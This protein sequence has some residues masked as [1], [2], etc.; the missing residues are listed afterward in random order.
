MLSR[1]LLSS[2]FLFFTFHLS[3]QTDAGKSIDTKLIKLSD[4]IYSYHGKG[5]NIGLSVGDDGIFMVDSQHEESMEGF[6][7][8][9]KKFNKSV[10]FL[11]NTHF[12]QDHTGGN[13]TMAKT[14]TIIVSQ[15]N[16][17]ERLQSKREKEGTKQP[18]EILPTITFSEELTFYF[19]NE[20]IQLIHIANAHTDGDA[21]VYFT[22]SNI[23]HTGDLL[24]NGKYPYIDLENGGNVR[25]RI[26]GLEKMINL[27]DKNTKIIPGHGPTASY[28]DLE[29]SLNLLSLT[30]RKIMQLATLGKTEDEVAKMKD[31]V[32]PYDAKGYGKGFV[33]TEDFLRILYKDAVSGQP[34]T[35]SRIEKNE[36]AREKYEQI[37]REHAKKNKKKG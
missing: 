15:E 17:R 3:A 1:L 5:G 31:I 25:A 2:A 27:I 36:E 9:I 19:N 16:T 35:Q 29:E 7:N 21:I 28:N 18:R 11:A 30:Y 23:L 8:D 20:K 12:H 34:N 6:L 33:K 32:G 22:D 10:R 37:K 14:G 13:P 26:T 24:F 4:K